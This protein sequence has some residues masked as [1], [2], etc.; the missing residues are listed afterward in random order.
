MYQ[1][2][3][4]GVVLWHGKLGIW[5][6]P[7]IGSGCFCGIDLIPGLGTFVFCRCG[8]KN[9]S[10]LFREYHSFYVMC[11]LYFTFVCCWWTFWLFPLFLHLWIMQFELRTLMWKYLFGSQLSF[12]L[13]RYLELLDHMA[14]LCFSFWSTAILFF[15]SWCTICYAYQRNVLGSSFSTSL[16]TLTF[17]ILLRGDN[18]LLMSVSILSL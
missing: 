8:Q 12:L 16:A 18:R 1:N 4:T 3:I 9:F 10:F 7:C 6:C 13:T 11:I 14:V 5:C 17:F 15:H 2:F